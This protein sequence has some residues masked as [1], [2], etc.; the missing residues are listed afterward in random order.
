LQWRR[1]LSSLGERSF[2]TGSRPRR[3]AATSAPCA[4]RWPGVRRCPASL[5]RYG[6]QPLER[7]N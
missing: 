6:P 4:V 1:R 5:P 2:P 3:C 7:R